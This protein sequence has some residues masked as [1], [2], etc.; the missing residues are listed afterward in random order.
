MNILIL[1]QVFNQT[2]NHL[3][4]NIGLLEIEV[5]VSVFLFTF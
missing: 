3:S 2:T 4:V 5:V 1:G